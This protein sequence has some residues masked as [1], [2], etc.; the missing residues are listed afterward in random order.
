MF[1]ENFV[2]LPVKFNHIVP[3]TR[4]KGINE[5]EPHIY[6]YV[7]HTS[8]LDMTSNF[9]RLWLA[10][11]IKTPF[12]NSQTF[13]N[14]FD[15]MQEF[16]RNRNRILQRI[17][18]LSATRKRAFFIDPQHVK[19]VTDFFGASEGDI[20]VNSANPNALVNLMQKENRLVFIFVNPDQFKEIKSRLEDS[21]FKENEDFFNAYE[22]MINHDRILNSYN[23]VAKM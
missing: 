2:K 14:I 17:I 18:Q 20:I 23:F 1:R 3:F 11:F 15:A 12:C 6:H 5:I 10:Y 16:M 8:D 21:N 19:L 7:S 4:W 13:G 9:S 22:I